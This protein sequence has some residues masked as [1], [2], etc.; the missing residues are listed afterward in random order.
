MLIY[1][2]NNSDI[3]NRMLLVDFNQVHLC[4]INS[5]LD[6]MTKGYKLKIYLKE[7]EFVFLDERYSKGWNDKVRKLYWNSLSAFDIVY[8]NDN[9]ISSYNG[10]TNIFN[11]IYILIID[12][13]ISIIGNTIDNDKNIY[14]QK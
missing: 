4:K 2:S 9:D 8:S 6:N 10:L 3:Q 13:T 14:G 5:L 7:N 12:H 11:N 1:T